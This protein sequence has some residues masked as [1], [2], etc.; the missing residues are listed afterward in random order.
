MSAANVLSLASSQREVLGAGNV[1]G[2]MLRAH[3]DWVRH[4]A[5]REDTIELFESLSPEVRQRAGS[6][7]AATWYPFSMLIEIDRAILRLFGGGEAAF[8]EQLGAYSAEMNLR[9]VYRSF[10]RAD[11]HDFFTRTAVLHRQFQDFGIARYREL[12]DAYGMMT[13]S[14]YTSYSPLYC[15]SAIGFYRAAVR[16]HG[17]ADVVVHESRCQCAGAPACVFDIAWR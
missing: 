10:R 13:H 2:S 14:G 5:S 12:D 17:G 4:H 6:I 11:V 16:L 7:L 3:L 9:G 15:A 1:K 8:L